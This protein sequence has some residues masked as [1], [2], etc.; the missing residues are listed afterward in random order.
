MRLAHAALALALLLPRA[1]SAAVPVVLT[2]IP[3]VQS[4][5]QM[6]LGDLGQASALLDRGAGAHDYQLRPSQ[7]AALQRADLLFWVGAE[8][9]PW[10]GRVLD[11]AAP[12]GRAVELLDAEG[13]L[14]RE[15]AEPAEEEAQV[16]DADHDHGS[17][18]PH[19][20]LDPRNAQHWLNLI[21]TEFAAVDPANATTY[22]GNAQ[23]A[24]ARIAALD[25]ELAALLAPL[26]GRGFVV[27]HDGYGYFAAR[28]GLQIAGTLADGDAAAPGAAHL[29]QLRAALQSG[30]VV[31][32]FPEA[33]H[34]PAQLQLLVAETPVRL[35]AALDPTGS[36]QPPGA[37]MYVALLD[38]LARNIAACLTDG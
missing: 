37:D 38:N 3:A 9:T 25:M 29:Q 14:R 4:L 28:Y 33:Q 23:A 22:A 16:D 26:S 27:A 8:L 34:A 24:A 13:T 20:W 2:D 18:D 15:F 11:S 1:A 17:I 12:A 7:R 19:A 10:L 30:A 35:G 31:C 32:A 36:M 5:A 21:A 6:V